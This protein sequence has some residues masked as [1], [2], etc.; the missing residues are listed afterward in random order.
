MTGEAVAEEGE[1]A[2]AADEAHDE[3]GPEEDEGG[4]GVH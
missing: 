3:D 1:G 4:D 2:E